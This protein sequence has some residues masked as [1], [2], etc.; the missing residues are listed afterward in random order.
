VN[1]EAEVFMAQIFGPGMDLAG[2]GRVIALG[3]GTTVLVAF[4]WAS[5]ASA[6]RTAQRQTIAQPLGGAA[7]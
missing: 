5:P 1:A 6:Y 2:R 4:V 7:S 3:L